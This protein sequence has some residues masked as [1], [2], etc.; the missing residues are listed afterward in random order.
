MSYFPKSKSDKWGTPP[1]LYQALNDEFHFDSFDPCP[2]SWTE[3]DADG[4][5]IDWTGDRIFVNPPYTNVRGW[6]AKC[7]AEFMKGKLIVLLT[8]NYTDSMWFHEFVYGKHEVRFIKGRLK[9]VR[10]D[11]SVGNANPRGSMISI[12]RGNGQEATESD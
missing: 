3:G 2:M 1:E 12:F 6:A 8:N 11:G 7:H 4:L 5:L 9:F 10:M